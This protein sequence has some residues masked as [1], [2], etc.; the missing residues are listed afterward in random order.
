MAEIGNK[1]IYVDDDNIDGPWDGSIDHPYRHIQDGIDNSQNGD[2]V[3]VFN[4]SYFENIVVHQ[5]IELYGEKKENT[6]VDGEGYCTVVTI[7]SHGTILSG[8]TIKNSGNEENDAGIVIDSG[9]NTI[10]ENEIQENYY[11]VRTVA[12]NNIIYHNNFVNNIYHAQD[13]YDNTWDNGYPSGGNFW[14]DYIGNDDNEDGIGDTPYNISDPATKDCYPLI[15]LYGSIQNLDTEKI[16]LTIKKAINHGTTHNGHT[17]YVK[18]DIYYE[19]LFIDKSLIILGEDKEVTIIDAREDES[20]V[21]VVVDD[22][23]IS[24]FTIQNSGDDLSNAGIRILSD[25]NIICDTIIQYNYHGIYCKCSSKDNDIYKNIIKNNDW[26]GIYV[27]SL[28]GGNYITKNT[29]ENNSYGGIAIAESSYN[30]IY[31]NN[32]I[33]NLH[34]A[35]DDSNN[36]W[37]NGYGTP[38]NP[39]VEG[40]NYWDDYEG[41]DFY[42]GA[43]QDEAGSDGIGDLHYE[44]N[45]GINKDRYPLIEPYG[46][47]GDTI[48]PEVEIT[49]PQNGLYIRNRQFLPFIFRQN[50]FIFGAVTVEVTASDMDSGIERVEFYIDSGP[51][52]T[53]VDYDPPYEWTWSSWSL[54]K[55]KHFIIVVAYDNAEN[56]EVDILS[57][58]KFF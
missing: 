7:T 9:C 24:N 37:D 44:V 22:V 15:H 51:T 38:F 34:N 31:H 39:L 3:Y 58:R 55:H 33:G 25:N 16:F 2:T 50:T 13:E 20:V 48:A 57:V 32:F 47:G 4:G 11:G 29:I 53:A 10:C 45:G 26:N 6:I 46:E 21:K 43:N 56:Y 18:K 23:I 27:K 36:L 14:D 28:L 8:F 52:P 5:S 17:I 41:W 42:S 19:H 35:F 54:L 40:G 30:T 12:Q 1:T 49:S